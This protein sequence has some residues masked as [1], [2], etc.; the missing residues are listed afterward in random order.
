MGRG[1]PSE[2]AN[3]PYRADLIH[4]SS[5][6]LN[7]AKIFRAR[8]CCAV[9]P[10]STFHSLPARSFQILSL[11]WSITRIPPFISYF[12]NRT[13]FALRTLMR[14][15]IIRSPASATPRLGG[16]ASLRLARNHTRSDTQQDLSVST[17]I[18]GSVCETALLSLLRPT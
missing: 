1:P 9:H 18:Q 17:Y 14:L 12:I 4:W 5:P 8:Y 15:R 7:A 13:I 11:G 2:I 16:H 10:P 3:R 6:P